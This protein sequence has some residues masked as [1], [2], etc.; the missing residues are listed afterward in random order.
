M[1][2]TT[3]QTAVLLIAHGSRHEPANEELRDLAARLAGQGGHPIVEPCFLELAEPS[4]AI[5][6]ARCA[7][8]G[9]KLVLMIPYFL[10]S[11]VH[12]LRD[13]TAA[14]DALEERFPGV[15]FRLGPPLGPHPLLDRL[16]AARVADLESGAAAPVLASSREM[17]RRYAPQDGAH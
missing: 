12:L 2:G 15:E 11:G 16:V 3:G 14:R 7:S 9:A 6:G 10:S 1:P 8:R 13:L 17:A 4:I 5:G